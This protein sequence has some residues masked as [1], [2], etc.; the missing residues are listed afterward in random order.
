MNFDQKQERRIV[1]A[2][3][4]RRLACAFADI[5]KAVDGLTPAEWLEV[6]QGMSSRMI[7]EQLKEDWK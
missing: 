2:E 3:A 4:G 7:Q 5:N 6:L 1:M